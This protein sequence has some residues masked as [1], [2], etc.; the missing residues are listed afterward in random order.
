MAK[1]PALHRLNSL[2]RARVDAPR[3]KPKQ[4]VVKLDKAPAWRHVL[5]LHGDD[6]S[7]WR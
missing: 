1:L 7:L 3:E 2:S 6:I 4:K 5:H